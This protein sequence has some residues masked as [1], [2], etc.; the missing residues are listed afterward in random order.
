MGTIVCQQ[1]N[2]TI[3]FFEDEK[4]TTLY[5]TCNHCDCEQEKRMNEK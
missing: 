5:G 2:H 1:C 3:D 4:V